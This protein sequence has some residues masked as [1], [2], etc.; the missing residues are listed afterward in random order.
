M[1]QPA[2]HDMV[3]KAIRAAETRTDGEI[4]VV[5]APESDSYADAVLHWSL[6]VALFPLALFATFPDLL[7]GATAL[8]HEPWGDDAPPLRLIVLVLLLTTVAAFLLAWAIFR[9][10]RLRMAITPHDTKVRRARRRAIMLFQVGTERRTASRSGVL[11]YLSL[12]EHHA[13]IVADELIQSKVSGGEW[14]EAMAALL[15]GFRGGRPGEGI[16]NAVQR[17]G[18][19]LATHFPHTGADPNEIPDRLIQL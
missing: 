10:P 11:L 4:S 6:L 18:Q 1:L 17:I 16:A 19:V 7:H 9:L 3:A 15:E 5:V 12:A 2:D 8:L 13:E 14:G